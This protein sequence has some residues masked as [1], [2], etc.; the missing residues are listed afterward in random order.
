MA[1]RNPK[2]GKPGYEE[3]LAYNRQWLN[4]RIADDPEYKKRRRELD[5]LKVLERRLRR[6]CP[7]RIVAWG[8]RDII[9]DIYK[10]CYA[11]N[12]T[13]GDCE[14]DHIVPLWSDDVC[15]LHCEANLAIITRE[16]N[17]RKGN[18]SFE[19]DNNVDILIFSTERKHD[20]KSCS[21][22]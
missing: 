4:R 13:G 11:L 18:T 15:G 9:E 22:L 17:K 7:Q 1:S 2:K 16:D 21:D 14:V 5:A 3:R 19:T 12:R 6:S 10:R 20:T 8:R